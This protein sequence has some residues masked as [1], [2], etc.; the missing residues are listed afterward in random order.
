M[1]CKML[2]TA[3]FTE[4]QNDKNLKNEFFNELKNSF[5]HLKNSDH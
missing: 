1:N 4:V 3:P 2:F 5:K